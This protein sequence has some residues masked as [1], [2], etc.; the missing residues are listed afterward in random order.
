VFAEEVLVPVVR[1]PRTGRTGGR[2]SV[3][4][5]SP[6]VDVP[7][8]LVVDNFQLLVV[9]AWSVLNRHSWDLLDWTMVKSGKNYLV[10]EQVSLLDSDS[11]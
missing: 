9:Q 4:H 5:R 8:A 7:E 11:R 2:S 10:E 3:V 1:S 6:Q